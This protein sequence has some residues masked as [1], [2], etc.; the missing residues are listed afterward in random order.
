M[1]RFFMAVAL[2]AAACVFGLDNPACVSGQTIA[3]LAG[4]V[5]L[6]CWTMVRPQAFA[7]GRK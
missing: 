2:I 4:A 5:V 3:C 6:L 1:I 7:R